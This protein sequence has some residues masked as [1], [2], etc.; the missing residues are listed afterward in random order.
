[1]IKLV[2][3][4][5]L[6]VRTTNLWWIFGILLVA[7]TA[8]SFTVSAL[9]AHFTLKNVPDTSGMTADQKAQVVAAS[10]VDNQ[11]ANLYTAGQYFGLLFVLILGVLVVT[12]EFFHQTATSTFLTMPKRSEVIVAKLMAAVGIGAAFWLIATVLDV[13]AGVVFL[14]AE[15]FDSQLGVGAVWRSILLNLLGYAI[16]TI[17]GVGLGALI[18][19]Q[20]ATVIIAI[21]VY[22]ATGTVAQGVAA[23]LSTTLHWD[24]APKAIVALPASASQLM[25]QGGH[26]IP[27]TPPQWLG[28][29]IL[30]AWG[31]VAG[32]IGTML[33]RRRDIT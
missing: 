20:I 33:T 19:S 3:S 24:W 5:L 15:G 12:N 32:V 10:H 18:R 13:V 9:T 4:E 7:F 25:I 27:G 30:I 22:F 2:R 21:V 26:S 23:I 1:M 31:V 8:L 6:K 14:R 11:A 16:W 29:V 17:V 28:A